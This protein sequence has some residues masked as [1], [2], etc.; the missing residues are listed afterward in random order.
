MSTAISCSWATLSKTNQINKIIG[1]WIHQLYEALWH[2][3]PRCVWPD[4]NKPSKLKPNELANKNKLILKLNFISTITWN[5]IRTQICNNW[6]IHH[7]STKL[8]VSGFIIPLD[9]RCVKT[10]MFI[11]IIFIILVRLFMDAMMEDELWEHFSGLINSFI[12]VRMH[13]TRI[14]CEVWRDIRVG[15]EECANIIQEINRFTSF[16][17]LHDPV[18]PWKKDPLFPNQPPKSTY[19]FT[20]MTFSN[21]VSIDV[22]SIEE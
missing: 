13:I 21:F 18:V 7:L 2:F 22:N 10:F 12:C 5:A 20:W 15:Q 14:W 11:I 16:V 19:Y 8:R 6:N 9:Y 17:L 4:S 1:L 3:S